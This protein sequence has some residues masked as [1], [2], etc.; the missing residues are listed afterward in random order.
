MQWSRYFTDYVTNE[1]VA[2]KDPTKFSIV[3]QIKTPMYLSL[4]NAI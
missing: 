3:Q 4:G 2:H 1:N